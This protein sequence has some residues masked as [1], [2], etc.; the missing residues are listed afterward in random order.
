[1]FSRIFKTRVDS[2]SNIQRPQPLRRLHSAPTSG[3]T[4]I[5][6]TVSS[7]IPS[8]TD[9]KLSEPMNLGFAPSS[10]LDALS[11]PATAR[12]L[13]SLAVRAFSG[14]HTRHA[15]FIA[16]YRKLIFYPK[17]EILCYSISKN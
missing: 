10:L 5:L 8:A 3:E 15:A 7:D 16:F 13:G 4:P 11:F 6:V 17:M 1:M 2:E 12:G 14:K 9:K